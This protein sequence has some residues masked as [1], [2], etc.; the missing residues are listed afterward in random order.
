MV[1]YILIGLLGALLL[2]GSLVLDDVID[3]LA[4]DLEFVSGPVIGAFMAAF[5]LFAW[6]ASSGLGASSLPTVAV[7]A[8]GGLLLAGFTYRVT[9]AL[10]NNPTDATPTTS[11]LVGTAGHV[12]TP[13][14]AGG[15]GEV[16]VTLGGVP[17][18]YTATAAV[19][20]ATGDRIVVIALESATKLRV[21]PEGQF[22][23]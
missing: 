22:W 18:K 6:F 15:I 17:T 21:E 2:V 4:P 8:G 20:L 13:V 3:G 16:L 5:G 12:V 11:T 1:V 7:G 19:D 23:T 14:P 10:L 9:A